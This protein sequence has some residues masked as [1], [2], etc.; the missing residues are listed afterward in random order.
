MVTELRI[1]RWRDDPGLF[2]WVLVRS[3]TSL[4]REAGGLEE[5]E[6]KGDVRTEHRDLKMLTVWL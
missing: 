1:L 2:R 3:Q 6:G 5:R 4:Y